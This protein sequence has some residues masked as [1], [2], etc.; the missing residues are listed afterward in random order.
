MLNWD[1]TDYRNVSFFVPRKRINV[2]RNKNLVDRIVGISRTDE[3]YRTPL[4]SIENKESMV[5]S[6]PYLESDHEDAAVV[7]G[8]DAGRQREARG[9]LVERLK[10]MIACILSTR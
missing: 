9:Q 8:Q 4:I 5:P 3:S 2:F 10:G 1:V 6:F 7:D